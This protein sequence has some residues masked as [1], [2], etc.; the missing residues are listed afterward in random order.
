MPPEHSPR[1]ANPHH[2]ILKTGAHD[3]CMKRHPAAAAATAALVLATGSAAAITLGT[4]GLAAAS[5][6]RGT[7]AG[8]VT[9]GPTCPVETD[10][11]DPNCAPRP[12]RA[13]VRVRSAKQA[14]GTKVVTDKTG[15]F[16]VRLRPG[17][18]EITI[19]SKQ[20]RFCQSQ[21]VT[22]RRNET[23]RAEISCDSGI[24]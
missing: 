2:R 12:I 20:A 5:S 23:T 21:T 24:R 4:P 11:P 13:T 22:V 6:A 15:K 9:V 8:R 18:Y 19:T 3:D 16:R 7:L 1:C 17:N 10:P 14:V